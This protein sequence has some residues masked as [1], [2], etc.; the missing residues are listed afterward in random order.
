MHACYPLLYEKNSVMLQFW[1]YNF[2]IILWTFLD[3]SRVN[4][5][6][7]RYITYRISGNGPQVQ[8]YAGGFT[9]GTQEKAGADSQHRPESYL[10][11]TSSVYT[12]NGGRQPR[13]HRSQSV[14]VKSRLKTHAHV[15][16]NHD[17]WPFFL[18]FG[19]T[20]VPL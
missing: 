2:K 7:W 13:R 19:N 20:H 10:S 11:D 18:S 6:P 4:S 8:G 16:L 3:A 12:A 5:G 1:W 15:P 17:I 14:N 9:G